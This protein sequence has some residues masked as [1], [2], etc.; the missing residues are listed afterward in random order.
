[1]S[2]QSHQKHEQKVHH[3]NHGA[4]KKGGLHKD[5]RAWTAV[6]LMLVGM[7]V[8]VISDDLSFWPGG[9]EQEPVPE[10]AE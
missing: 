2:K 4:Q 8:Y 9:R 6:I 7:A 10:A 5:W 1:M 3:E